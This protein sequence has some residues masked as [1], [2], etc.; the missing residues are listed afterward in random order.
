MEPVFIPDVKNIFPMRILLSLITV[1]PALAFDFAQAQTVPGAALPGQ[2][3]RQFETPREFRTLP[4]APVLPAPVLQPPAGAEA[5]GFRLD[6]VE[7]EGLTLTPTAG[8]QDLLRI[9][10]GRETTLAGLYALADRLT[11]RLRGDGYLLARV[12]VPPQSIENG[13][14]RL[15]V[16]EGY[17]ADVT[18]TGVESGQDTLIR[19]YADRIRTARPLTGAVLERYMLLINDLPGVFA[20]ATLSPAQAEVGA[21][22]L[23]IQVKQRK[24]HAG[25]S[26]DNRGGSSLGEYRLIGDAAVADLLRAGQNSAVKLVL[27]PSG[28]L[29]YL[30]LQHEEA[31]GREGGR[32]GISMTSARARPEEQSFIPLELETRSHALQFTYTHPLLRSRSRNLSLRAGLYLH[33]GEESVFGVRDRQ[34]KLRSLRLGVTWDVRD[35]WRGSNLFDLEWSRGLGG[36]GASDNGDPMLTRAEGRV[37]YSK[38]NLFAARVQDF[39]GDWSLLT[40]LSGQY[41]QDNLLASELFGF[42][43][44]PFGRGYDPSELVGDHGLGFKLELRRDGRLPWAGEQPLRLYGFYDAGKVWQ[45]AGGSD[46]AASAGIGARVSLN[47]ETTLTLELA[48]PLTHAV[49]AEGNKSMRGYVGVSSR[50]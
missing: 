25:L 36:L 23:Q 39:S 22:D 4:A 1:L 19:A 29:A 7:L 34:D 40:A 11:A 16:I 18:L 5:V 13:V 10:P 8:F 48:K 24:W 31:V 33:N 17:I 28:E 43:G 20:T 30:A 3:E 42:G 2:I 45:R 49:A 50:F 14:A 32:F 21:A 35:A 9:E 47:R 26:A 46:S 38:L 12:V 15:R 27:S 37:D 44:E 41:A 6:R